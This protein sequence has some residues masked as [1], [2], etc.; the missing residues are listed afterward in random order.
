MISERDIGEHTFDYAGYQVTVSATWVDH[1]YTH[2][3]TPRYEVYAT[4]KRTDG[5]VMEHFDAKAAAPVEPER[6]LLGK[7]LGV[8]QKQT[9]L[10]D[11]VVATCDDIRKQIDTMY[12]QI[13][14]NRDE[15]TFQ[16]RIEAEAAVESWVAIN[17]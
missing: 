6:S 17:E 10:E 7:I 16:S 4:A 1:E 12:K 8:Q 5:T 14:V 11:L 13:G 15:D 2:E 9:E 3:K